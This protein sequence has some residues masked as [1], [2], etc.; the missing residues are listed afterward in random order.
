LVSWTVLLGDAMLWQLVWF[1][2]LGLERLR[3][4]S[5]RWSRGHGLITFVAAAKLREL[6][7]ATSVRP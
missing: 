7:G 1:R 4:Y 5:S 2:R 3:E 6:A